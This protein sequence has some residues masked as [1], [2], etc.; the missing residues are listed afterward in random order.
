[1]LSRRLSKI[2]TIKPSCKSTL[3]QS[4]AIGG[5]AWNVLVDMGNGRRQKPG[6]I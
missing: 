5:N 6:E 1:M 3:K 2:W 4:K